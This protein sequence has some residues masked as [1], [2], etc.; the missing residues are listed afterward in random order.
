M[1]NYISK[2]TPLGSS[3]TYDIKAARLSNTSKVG[4]TNKPVYFTADGVPAAISYTIDK[5][6]PSNAV[7]TD[8]DTKQNIV[9][10]TTAKAFITGVTTTPTSTAQALTGIADTSVYLTTTEGQI[11]ATTYKIAEK[12]ILQYNNTT[13]ALDFVFV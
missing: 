9:L 10:N 7:F 12:V 4:D 5:S 1:A 8:T 11:N 13:D 3:I 6:V 2:I